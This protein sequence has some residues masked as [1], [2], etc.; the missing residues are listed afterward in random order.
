MSEN[1]K[2]K[3][4]EYNEHGKEYAPY[5]DDIIIAHLTGMSDKEMANVCAKFFIQFLVSDAR[6]S[7]PNS[8]WSASQVKKNEINAMKSETANNMSK[9]P[10]TILCCLVSV[11]SGFLNFGTLGVFLVFFT[12]FFFAIQELLFTAKIQITLNLQDI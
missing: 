3:S 7:C 10:N 11:K 6:V 8:L 1:Q 5:N 9:L 12:V 2:S 4:K